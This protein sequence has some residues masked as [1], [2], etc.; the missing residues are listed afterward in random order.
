[1]TLRA[2]DPLRLRGQLRFDRYLPILL[3]T[4][5]PDHV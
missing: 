3:A 1:M 2:A 4:V 5:V